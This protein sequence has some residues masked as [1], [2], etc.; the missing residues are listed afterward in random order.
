MTKPRWIALGALGAL[1]LSFGVG[2]VT[3]INERKSEA[4]TGT[5]SVPTLTVML[6]GD[7]AKPS[8]LDFSQFWRAWRH[9]DENF[10]ATHA[11]AT[12]PSYKERVYG[13]IEGLVES[14]GDPYTTFFPPA[15]AAIF[16]AD[17]AGLFEGVGMEIG[18]IDDVLAVVAP[19][20]NSPAEKAGLMSG[21][22]I[23]AIDGAPAA[24]LKVERR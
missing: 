15:D 24:K 17:V 16:Q 23:V 18:I 4:A 3:G 1:A 2:V 13:A 5:S 11:S 21:D 20:K 6:G 19:L 7:S 12:I 22:K 9:L 10:V 8:D 14:Y